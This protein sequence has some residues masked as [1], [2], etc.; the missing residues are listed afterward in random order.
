MHNLEEP[1]LLSMCFDAGLCTGCSWLLSLHGSTERHFPVACAGLP[2]DGQDEREV[3]RLLV[4]DNQPEAQH[5]K[6][7][8]ARQAD[9][10][11][12][13]QQMLGTCKCLGVGPK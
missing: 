6:V 10:A 1:G 3:Y 12:A 5:V 4:P 9:F 11:L 7:M 8:S 13:H 2:R